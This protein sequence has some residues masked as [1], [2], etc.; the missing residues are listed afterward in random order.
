MQGR[1]V[2]LLA[3]GMFAAGCA[4]WMNRDVETCG[5]FAMGTWQPYDSTMTGQLA[6][7]FRLIMIS[8]NQSNFS[9]PKRATLVVRSVVPRAQFG[10]DS[11]TLTVQRVA[12]DG[13]SG[14]YEGDN[15]SVHGR[16]CALRR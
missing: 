4:R 7:T 14:L 16:F 12:R 10:R 11:V 9:E 15:K 5:K 3:A 1:I 6:G 13:F 8:E 2:A